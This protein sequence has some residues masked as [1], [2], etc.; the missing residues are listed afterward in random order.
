M[1]TEDV[2]SLVE[3]LSTNIGDLEQSLAPLL[4]TALSASTSKLP[5]LDKAK[6][7]V[8]ATYAIESILFSALRLNGTDAKSHPVF[9]ELSRV[10]DYFG[11][12]KSAETAGL[13]RPTAVDKEA[14]GR[15][16]KADLAGND[17]YDKERAERQ[18]NEKAGAKRKL[19]EMS[20][21]THTRFDG[22]AKRIRAE[23]EEGDEDAD[24]DEM[25]EENEVAEPDRKGP[26][27]QAAKRQR[28]AERRAARAAREAARGNWPRMVE[29]MKDDANDEVE[30]G[31]SVAKR[32]KS[33][34][35]PKSHSETF[36]ALLQGPLPKMEDQK[37]S[38]RKKKKSLQN[39]EDRRAEEM[40]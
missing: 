19:E 1:D 17:K 29:N 39:L 37:K 16:I 36:Q 38:R 4:K 8:L 7:Y 5:L 3:D 11:K 28:K 33:C 18:A 12:I 34:K 10:K 30:N 6:L 26:G 15:F 27:H 35:A 22:A 31:V 14:A 2:Q 21:G 9:Q 24:D 40:Q 13:K 20:V 32:N 23:E 25:H